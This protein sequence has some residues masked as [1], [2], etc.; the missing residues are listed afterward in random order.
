MG[1]TVLV[2]GASSGFG[3]LTA[4]LL[5]SRGHLVFGT[6]RAP[7][8]DLP[9]VRVLPLDVTDGESVRRCLGQ[10]REEAGRIDVLINNA[11]SGIAGAIADTTADEARG[12][13]ETNF[14]GVVRMTQ[15]VLPQMLARGRGRI[16]TAGSMGGHAGLPFQ[17]FY[18]ASKFALEGFNEA[19][20]LELA[21]T[22]VDATIVCPGDFKT[23][24]TAARRFAAASREG[25][26][27]DRLRRTMAIY[28]RDEARGSSPE[29][30]AGLLARLVAA[31]KV[32]VRYFA[33]NLEQRAGMLLKRLLP[34]RLFEALMRHTYSL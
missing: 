22:G 13:F 9:G 19:L 33:G 1:K 12:Q 34:A 27:A 23:G 10:V 17:A 18:S 21:G 3:L 6:S 14:W 32:D 5:A 29:A 8:G 11:G 20:R 28:E 7:K 26:F 15:A 4:R 16:V 25:L 31:P 24:F 30:V 2:T